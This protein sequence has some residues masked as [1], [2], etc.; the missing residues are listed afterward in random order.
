MPIKLLHMTLTPARLYTTDHSA[1]SYTS[2]QF[3]YRKLAT[4]MVMQSIWLGILEHWLFP[5]KLGSWSQQIVGN[6]RYR[7]L[8]ALMYSTSSN[9]YVQ[10]L[11]L[12]EIPCA[13]TATIYKF[14]SN[15]VST[16]TLSCHFYGPMTSYTESK[17]PLVLTTPLMVCIG[18]KFNP[19]SLS[20]KN[21]RDFRRKASWYP[22]KLEAEASGTVPESKPP[23]KEKRET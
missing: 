14:L 2:I 8:P 7:S 6:E 9:Q 3:Q 17:S 23:M 20:G 15:L 22:N 16:Q 13:Q 1:S 19:K 10:H 4:V 21:Q 18:I 11:D 5:Y 12:V